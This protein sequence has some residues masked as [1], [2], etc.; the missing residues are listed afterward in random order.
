MSIMSITRE[1]YQAVEEK[2]KDLFGDKIWTIAKFYGT[3]FE[4]VEKIIKRKI[5]EAKY[6]KKF[7]RYQ[8]ILDIKIKTK[9][10]TFSGIPCITLIID[11]KK[12]VDITPEEVIVFEENQVII[13]ANKDIA[14]LCGVVKEVYIVITQ[15]KKG[16]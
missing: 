11:D 7:Y 8:A 9:R 2:L 3:D 13:N 12:I 5:K 10:Y 16:L 4:T 15:N 1:N 14:V 6:I